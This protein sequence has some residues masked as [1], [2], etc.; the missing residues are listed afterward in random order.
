MKQLCKGAS[1]LLAMLMVLMVFP[2]SAMAEELWVRANQEEPQRVLLEDK[3]TET[4]T[5]YEN[6]DGTYT[7]EVTQYPTRVKD[8]KGRWQ[9]VDLSMVEKEKAMVREEDIAKE[10]LS[11]YDYRTKAGYFDVLLKE[12]AREENPVLVQGDG[13][14]IGIKPM[15]ENKLEEKLPQKQRIEEPGTQIE[16]SRELEE[17]TPQIQEER[18]QEKEVVEERKLTMLEEDSPVEEAKQESSTHIG[19]EYKDVFEKGAHVR[20]YPTVYGYKEEIVLDKVPETRKFSFVLDIGELEP[21]LLESGEVLLVD[22]EK[23]KEEEAT[24]I[25]KGEEK[26]EGYVCGVVANIPI[27]YMV[28][29]KDS[30]DDVLDNYDIEVELTQ[31]E[32]GSWIY[33]L[34]PS[35]TYLEAKERIYPV[36]IDPSIVVNH[37]DGSWGTTD[38]DIMSTGG[39]YTNHNRLRVGKDT[40]NRTYRSYLWC[41]TPSVLY[42][43]GIVIYNATIQVY[44]SSGSTTVPIECRMVKDTMF[45][46]INWYNQPAV[47][48]GFSAGTTTVVGPGWYGW[49]ITAPIRKNKQNNLGDAVTFQLISTTENLQ[50]VKS[51]HSADNGN[52]TYNPRWTFDYYPIYVGANV[53]PG[54]QSSSVGHI[55]INWTDVGARYHEVYM[56][57]T[58]MGQSNGHTMTLYNVSAGSSHSIYIWYYDAFWVPMGR[59]SNLTVAMP[60]RVPPQWS[61]GAPTAYMDGENIMLDFPNASDASGMSYY[62]LWY[63]NTAQSTVV[64]DANGRITSSGGAGRIRLGSIGASAAKPYAINYKQYGLPSGGRIKLALWGIDNNSNYTLVGIATNEITLP[65]DPPGAPNSLRVKRGSQEYGMGVTEP[66]FAVKDNGSTA[67][68]WNIPNGQSSTQSVT[69]VRYSVD[70]G[71][72]QNISQSAM[73]NQEAGSTVGNNGANLS[74][75][76]VADGLHDVRIWGVDGLGLEGPKGL[77]KVLVDNTVPEVEIVSPSTDGGRIGESVEVSGSISDETS[78]IAGW[79][80]YV[81]PGVGARPSGLTAITSGTSEEE[82][83]LY[84]LDTTGY[85]VGTYTIELEAEDGAGNIANAKRRFVKYIPAQAASEL[86]VYEHEGADAGVYGY[87]DVTGTTV[88]FHITGEIGEESGKGLIGWKVEKGVGSLYDVESIQYSVNGGDPVTIL[89]SAFLYGS[90]PKE[91]R[92]V[93]DLG[94]VSGENTTKE[95]TLWGVDENGDVGS[96]RSILI[97]V[98][99]EVPEVAVSGPTSNAPWVLGTVPD[100]VETWTNEATIQVDYGASGT[101]SSIVVEIEDAEEENGWRQL[102]SRDMNA[103]GTSFSY[104]LSNASGITAGVSRQIRVVARSETGVRGVY[105]KRFQIAAG[106]VERPA[107]LEIE[108]MMGA[109]EPE[110]EGNA[111]W[112]SRS[113]EA[114]MSYVIVKVISDGSNYVIDPNGSYDVRMYVN[115][116]EVDQTALTTIPY[117][118]QMGVLF[119]ITGENEDLFPIDTPLTLVFEVENVDTGE[120]AYTEATCILTSDVGIESSSFTSHVGFGFDGDG[121]KATGTESTDTFIYE[122]TPSEP[123]MERISGL[124]VDVEGTGTGQVAFV[125]YFTDG[126]EESEG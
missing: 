40:S 81:Y 48:S 102:Y 65:N 121:M 80:M 2:M 106:A 24:F 59:T 93:I 86:N 53:T 103:G 91:N 33:T 89:S 115:G 23:A 85:A 15:V 113:S 20:V 94:D 78:G 34:I 62:E 92:A 66:A 95:V 88:P 31:G 108:V 99:S 90:N 98:D 124:T 120:R 123:L 11:A 51:F 5:Y 3:N 71:P 21:I 83:E 37:L 117:D 9:D 16:G 111:I 18:I 25:E 46:Q 104:S 12:D 122:Y 68:W 73:L 63:Y 97:K 72:T 110:E 28:D 8:A 125:V 10:L 126:V 56:D 70:D 47:Y 4:E 74:L 13:F 1:I 42:Q 45:S 101:L 61:S 116:C 14:T 32:D 19:G 54:G 36:I 7:V 58:Y 87:G 114:G 118:N 84:T 55:N 119:F 38:M 26:P 96:K 60:D 64:T 52:Q 112:L 67:F 57:G 6:P 77:V 39:G 100:E 41:R 75:L 109:A 27:P 49:N 22:G 69:G 29:S 35:R 107:E 50:R 43:D 76:G 82:G 17:V 105:T 79:E 44:L 30:T